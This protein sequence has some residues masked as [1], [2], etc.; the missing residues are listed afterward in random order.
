MIIP[1]IDLMNGRAVQ[2]LGGREKV[3]DAGD[4]VP[5]AERFRLA[6]EIAVIDLDAALGQGSN[7]ETIRRLL[8]VASCRVGG[9]IRT[10]DQALDWLDAGAAK[11]ILGTAAQPEILAQLP[12]ERVIAALDAE[13]GEIVVQGW[14]RRT[15]LAVAERMAELRSLVSGF[16]VTFVEHEGRMGGIDPARAEALVQVAGDAKL[17]LAGGVRT[18]EEIAALDRLGVDCQVG[19]AIYTGRLDLADAIVAPLISDRLD[20]LWPTVVVDEQGVA[21]GLAWS[22]RQSLREAVHSQRGIY[23]SRK[24][25]IWKKGESSG[26]TQDLLRVDLDCDRDALRFTVRQRGDGFCHLPQR[27]CWGRPGGI[28]ELSRRLSATVAMKASGSYT[29]RLLDTPG[30]LAA[31]LLEEAE[32]LASAQGVSDVVHEAADVIYFSLVAA[33]RGGASLE[34]I[35]R[36]LDRRALVVRRRPGNAKPAN[37]GKL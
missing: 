29:A 25:G 24:R 31:K 5:I 17:T 11:V 10:L 6:G 28:G 32:E 18:A 33:I 15:G 37:R 30:L 19:M 7:A 35:E 20:G 27:T 34:M 14:R 4:P 8:K 13:H 9:G 1:S 36:E 12:R 22:D 23:H 16:L 3:L 26:A 21:L 2:L